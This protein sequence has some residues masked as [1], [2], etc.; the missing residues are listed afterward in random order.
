VHAVL[1]PL[2]KSF[3]T[4]IWC[5][6]HIGRLHVSTNVS[7]LQASESQQEA[8][9]T[10]QE[11]HV[12]ERSQ[13]QAAARKAKK[14]RQKAKRQDS[15]ALALSTCPDTFKAQ[16]SAADQHQQ[17]EPTAN[18]SSQGMSLSASHLPAAKQLPDDLAHTTGQQSE[19]AAALQDGDRSPDISPLLTCQPE[20]DLAK[21]ASKADL[22]HKPG[23]KQLQ[24]HNSTG[25]QRASPKPVSAFTTGN[26]PADGPPS[27]PSTAAL[28]DS[29]T[30]APNQTAYRHS[31]QAPS[32]CAMSASHQPEL[33]DAIVAPKHETQPLADEIKPFKQQQE[34]KFPCSTHSAEQ[35]APMSYT[36][37]GQTKAGPAAKHLTGFTNALVPNATQ[38]T[39]NGFEMQSTTVQLD[40]SL[41]APAGT[42]YAPGLLCCPLTKVS[43]LCFIV[44]SEPCLHATKPWSLLPDCPCIH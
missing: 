16:Q 31:P 1:R 18:T 22:C 39:H 19:A 35:Q 33:S 20:A 40:R 25:L 8:A 10:G 26:I 34:S 29:Q 42:T 30:L 15:H 7:L 11:S 32:N 23:Q 27:E 13:A 28:A 21:H 3:E 12:K 24:R 9:A 5:Q 44:K 38:N 4:C 41:L 43:T 6:S 37:T 14:Q 2:Q 17:S 36:S